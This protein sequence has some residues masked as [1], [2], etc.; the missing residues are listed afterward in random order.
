MTHSEEQ[1]STDPYLSVIVPAHQAV[2]VLPRC[3]D[4]ITRSDFPRDRMELIV[5]D[6]ASSDETALVAAETADRVIRLPGNPRGPA[7]ARNRGVELSRGEVVVFVDSD[8]LV[9]P[10]TLSGFARVLEQRPDVAAVFGSY[11]DEPEDPGMVSQYRNLLH[12]YVHLRNAGEAQTFWAGC[13]A[14]RK[15]ALE[16]VGLYD[17]WHYARPQIE[18]IELGRRLSRHGHTILLDPTIQG[19]HLKRWTLW[20]ML[21]TDF[22]HRGVPWMWLILH[23]GSE[24]AS[25]LNTRSI[26]KWSTALMGLSLAALLLALVTTEPAFLAL[27]VIG[28][29]FAMLANARLF[30]YL[31]RKRGIT[32]A[33]GAIPLHMGYYVVNSLSVI[34]GWA[35]RHLWGEP[36]P[37][38][39]VAAL[40]QLGL[41]I[42]PPPPTKPHKGVWEETSEAD[43]SRQDPPDPNELP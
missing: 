6:D 18:D 9:H 15:K 37:P 2:E 29:A 30:G 24:A 25:A 23:E 32:F 35:M 27:A 17:E 20:G 39:D 21:S 28:P 12:H 33:A 19:T 43:R 34:W 40:S 10:D 13:G 14:V 36:Q 16:D 11:D 3:L 42:W 5:V 7:Y 22:R 26:E 1:P 8:V 38:E 41:S 31:A 4:A